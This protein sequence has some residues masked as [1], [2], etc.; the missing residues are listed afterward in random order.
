MTNRERWARAQ[1]EPRALMAALAILFGAVAAATLALVALAPGPPPAGGYA[2]VAFFVIPGV[3][4]AGVW[5]WMG[6]VRSR[7]RRIVW[8]AAM[9]AIGLA[10]T[11]QAGFAASV[12]I[13]E[14]CE[15]CFASSPWW[16]CWLMGCW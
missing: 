4:Y 8:S 10:V 3:T 5:P 11:T 14:P 7:P 2:M 6:T 16:L 15:V 9:L 12:P 13:Q 1:D